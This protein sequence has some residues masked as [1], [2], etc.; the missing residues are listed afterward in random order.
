MDSITPITLG[1]AVGQAILGKKSGNKAILWGAVGGAIPDLDYIPSLF[2]DDIVRLTF[3]RGFT[4]SILFSI[5]LAP[6]F[7]YL[8]FQLYKKKTGANFK[9][10]T[11]LIFFSLITHIF[12]DCFTIYG[13]QIFYPFSNYRVAFSSISIIDPLYTIPFLICIIAVMFFKRT[14][15]KRQV[16]N[17][18]GLGI[19]TLYLT[20]TLINKYY[21]T[22]V[23]KNSLKKQ[24]VSYTRIIA[25]PTIFN[26]IF[27]QGIAES[28]NC[29]YAGGYSLMDNT[30]DIR[31]K[32]IKKNYHLIQKIKD[33]DTMKKL[34]RFSKGYLSIVKKEDYLMLNDIRYGLIAVNGNDLSYFFS[35]KISYEKDDPKKLIIKMIH[36]K[37]IK[38]NV[39]IQF[40][41]RILGNK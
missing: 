28:K 30:K 6:I 11:I 5:V 24:D 35:F 7:G 23:F 39:F 12:L 27:W 13:T 18:I 26:N 14:S 21:V 1:A 16:L 36:P 22:S 3:H 41:K 33:E 25:L 37:K 2:M 20:F 9:G 8:I 4:H 10:W 29:F 34:F 38:K 19:S 32:C 15:K 31:F 40:F 17:Y